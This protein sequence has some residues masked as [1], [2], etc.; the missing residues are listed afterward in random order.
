MTTHL[1][2]VLRFREGVFPGPQPISIERRHFSLLEKGE[3]VVSPKADGQRYLLVVKDDVSVLINRAF[4]EE[5]ISFRFKRDA[6]SGTILDV[7]RVNNGKILVFDAYQV[8]GTV[9]KDLSL[10]ERLSH[11]ENVVKGIL[12]TSK[13]K[14]RIEMKPVFPRKDVEK[15]IFGDFDYE[16]DGLIFTPVKEPIRSGTHE[17]MFK[18]KPKNK[19]TVDFKFVPSVKLHDCKGYF[20]KGFDQYV[21]DRGNLIMEGRLPISLAPKQFLDLMERGDREVVIME[22]EYIHDKENVSNYWR[23]IIH[24]KDK[25]FPNSRRTFQRTLVN[26]EE[27]IQWQEF[28]K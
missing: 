27:D 13:D 18:W 1:H 26:I 14:V 22:C 7:E 6:K 21:Q 9:V 16:T 4:E 28:K 11:A 17:T 24:R 19:N 3:Y 12:K 15:A 25:T 23:P 2:K 8:N 10:T 20:E 5:P